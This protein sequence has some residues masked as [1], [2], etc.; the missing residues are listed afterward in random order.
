ME[1]SCVLG[2]LGGFHDGRPRDPLAPM[3]VFQHDS[4]HERPISWLAGQNFIPFGKALDDFGFATDRLAGLDLVAWDTCRPYPPWR[5]RR[6]TQRLGP[7]VL[8]DRAG[9]DRERV[10]LAIGTIL[11]EQAMPGLM[12]DR[13]SPIRSKDRVELAGL[14][15]TGKMLVSR[16]G[17]RWWGSTAAM[18][19]L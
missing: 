16:T 8:E 7:F 4:T 13:S 3:P 2:R 10:F 9:R 5:R 6:N 12:T 17:S 14:A 11:T 19:G 1:L 18:T 15:G